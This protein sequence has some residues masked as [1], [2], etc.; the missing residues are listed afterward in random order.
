M[1]FVDVEAALEL[2]GLGTLGEPGLVAPR[3]AIDVIG[4]RRRARYLLGK[5]R[6]RV[7]LVE[8]GAG[9][10]LYGKLVEGAHLGTRDE[11]LPHVTGLGL[12]KRV[13]PLVPIV[14]L[15]DYVDALNPRCPHGK[16]EAPG[17]ILVDGLVCAQLV[18]AAIPL[19]LC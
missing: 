12:G 16:V 6:V 14:E 11:A 2:I 17:A 18:I 15:A 7:C 19:A 5:E 9:V 3:I 1:H 8:P 13:G 10:C 4:A